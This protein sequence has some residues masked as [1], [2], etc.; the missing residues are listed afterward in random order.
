M[1]ETLKAMIEDH[2]AVTLVNQLSTS[3]DAYTNMTGTSMATPH[4]TGP[5]RVVAVG[6]PES[7]VCRVKSDHHEY[8]G[9]GGKCGG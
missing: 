9:P 3:P 7:G 5:C 4:V 6:Q 8:G 1:G 2:P